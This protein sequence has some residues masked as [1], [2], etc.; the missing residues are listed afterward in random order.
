[1]EAPLL[2]YI[3]GLQESSGRLG[4]GRLRPGEVFVVRLTVSKA[5]VDE[6]GEFIG[7]DAEGFVVA[8]SAGAQPVAEGSSAR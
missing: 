4:H 7:H 5:G 3:P 6:A 8:G 1:M 2:G